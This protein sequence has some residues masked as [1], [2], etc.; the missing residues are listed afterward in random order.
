MFDTDVRSSGYVK[1][2]GAI[3]ADTNVKG[4]VAGWAGTGLTAIL[5]DRRITEAEAVV[6]VTSVTPCDVTL[7]IVDNGTQ[8]ALAV[9][10]TVDGEQEPVAADVSYHFEIKHQPAK[11][12]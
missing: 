12:N 1:V 3:H 5:L 9:Q 6:K 10:T 7:S 4:G 8:S 11:A 2:V